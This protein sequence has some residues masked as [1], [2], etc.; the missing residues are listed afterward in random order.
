MR[1]RLFRH[2]LR[3]GAR[4]LMG[5]G[6]PNLMDSPQ[7]S[8]G[9]WSL[10]AAPA[11]VQFCLIVRPLPCLQ[12]R[13][14]GNRGDPGSTRCSGP[15]P[16]R[17][18]RTTALAS[19]F[20]KLFQ[21]Q[22]KMN[23]SQ[24]SVLFEDISVD[25]TQKEWQLLDPA[26]RLLYRDVMLENYRHLVSLGHCVT[27][28]E[29]I[30]KLEQ[31]EEPWV[32]KKEL[33]SQSCPEV[34]E[35]NNMKERSQAKEDKYSRKAFFFNNRIL[36]KERT[37]TLRNP[38]PSRKISHKCDLSGTSLESVSELIISNRNHVRKTSSDLNGWGSLHA[39]H[40]KIHAVNKP[41]ESDQKKKSHRY[42]EEFIQHEKNSVLEKL[43]EYNNCGKVFHKKTAF[44]THKRPHKG[45]KPSEDNEYRQAFTQKLKLSA[46]PK[47]LK[48]RKSCESS[49]NKKPS[50]MKSTH[51]HQRAHL[52]EKH[53]DCNKLGK[54]F[55]RKSNLTQHQKMY[56][57]GTPDEYNESERALRKSYHTQSDRTHAG[58]KICD[59]DKCGKSFHEKP[60]LTQHQRTHT[61]EKP[62]ECN[63]S[64]RAIRKESHLTQSQRI[65]TRGKSFQGSKCEK[66]SCEKLK[67]AQH[68][69][70]HSGRKTNEYHKSGRTISKKSHLTQS[71]KAHKG[72]KA[73][74][75]NKCGRSFPKKTDLTQH[76][77]T[78]TGKKPYECNECG[79]SFFVKSNLTEHQ[80]T[81]TGEK[82]YECNECGKS[83]CQKS[84]LTV[85][86]RTHT[87][88]KPYK[89]NDCGKTFCVKSNLTQHQ[90]THTGEKPYKCNECWRSFCVKSNLV[91]H[92]RT[93]TGEKPYKCP[94]CGKTFYEKSA[95]TKHQRIHTGEKPYECNECRKT[96]SQRSAL[97]KHQRKTHKKKT[98]I[99]AARMQK[100]AS[101]NQIR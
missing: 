16:A 75:C 18:M 77:S 6:V 62:S 1:Q 33:P 91:V 86:Q 72:K 53:Y 10:A 101:T 87:G 44:V 51:V 42:K 57:G 99:N 5:N 96:F 85:H 60:C 50:C 32:P 26:Q 22:E 25:F 54:S 79:K 89:C 11:H 49:K 55:S 64:E 95:L 66:S 31:G 83:F 34:Q 13:S 7:R 37:K 45:E 67:F 28:P 29:L 59:S 90:R 74:N 14:A 43:L 12:L 93:H 47:T 82:P 73:Y 70:M 2:S 35:A 39:M 61:K 52:G 30:F 19:E 71:Q 38:V 98:P 8:P 46:H 78:H 20:S 63:D 84:A 65:N 76:Q 24:G 69:R 40:E 48:E 15:S 88:E 17:R 3:K 27:K 81:H 56:R 97:T 58:E 100:P 9:N 41:H 92:Q 68:Q 94:E 80:R 36:T 23:R 21:E 4:R